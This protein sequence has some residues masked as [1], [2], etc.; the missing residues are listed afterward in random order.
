MD[1]EQ[2]HLNAFEKYFELRQKGKN[3]TDCVAGVASEF[4]RSKSTI[5]EW[6]KNFN[7]D[8]REAV[9]SAEINA[10]VQKKTNNT[11]ID[12]KTKYLSYVHAALN[13]VIKQN[14]DGS[15]DIDL[16][17]DKVRDMEILIKL[18]LLLQGEATDRTENQ[19]NNQFNSD[20]QKQILD[21][22]SNE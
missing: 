20:T 15:V 17:V 12:N 18:G 7:W 14:P 5:F 13:K 8:D 9:R 3:K 21:E 4:N 10:E 19:N 11:I 6:K 2:I 22:G 1:E 16:D